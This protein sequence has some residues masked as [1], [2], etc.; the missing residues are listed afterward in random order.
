MA[1]CKKFVVGHMRP[2]GHKFDILA[3]EQVDIMMVGNQH[4]KMMTGKLP[5]TNPP[6]TLMPLFP[7]PLPVTNS[8][9]KPLGNDAM[10]ARKIKGAFSCPTFP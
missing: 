10:R 6:M 9:R 7:V 3:L 2:A 8:G 1:G 4:N 5:S